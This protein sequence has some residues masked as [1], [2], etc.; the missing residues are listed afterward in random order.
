MGR[1]SR[2]APW[3]LNSE[4]AFSHVK[5]HVLVRNRAW[6]RAAVLNFRVIRVF[7]GMLKSKF[8]CAQNNFIASLEDYLMS[9]WISR[10]CPCLFR[11]TVKP[12][13]KTT[14]EIG[15]T[16]EL[17]TATSVP[18]SIYYIEMDLRNKTISK[19]RTVFGSPLSVPNSQVP[20][21]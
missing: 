2:N 11:I 7:L 15:T 14:W 9:L 3:N 1:R 18:R 8:H 13:F 17:R 16:W 4:V 20:L 6:F 21:Y 12:I 10:F 5:F 19:F